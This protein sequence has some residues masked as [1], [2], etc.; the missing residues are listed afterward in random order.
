MVDQ[1]AA[2]GMTLPTDGT[3]FL[4]WARTEGLLP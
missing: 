4:E 1:L 3:G 2:T